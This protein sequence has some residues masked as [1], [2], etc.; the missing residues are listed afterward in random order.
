MSEKD[1]CVPGNNSFFFIECIITRVKTTTME[2]EEEGQESVM[3]KAMNQAQDGSPGSA[4]LR[5]TNSS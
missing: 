4:T 1:Q 2:A 5:A 3:M